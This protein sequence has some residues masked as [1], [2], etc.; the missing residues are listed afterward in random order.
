MRTRFGICQGVVMSRQVIPA[1]GCYSL[2][3]MVGQAAAV[4]A[5]RH[6][7]G[8]VE[9]VVRIVHLI[10]PEDLLEAAFIK[11]TVMRHER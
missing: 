11:G 10:H 2:E 6:S 7:Q 3:L 1:G 9:L 4:N 8:V 5:A